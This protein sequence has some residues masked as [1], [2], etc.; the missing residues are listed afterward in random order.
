MSIIYI[1]LVILIA[2]NLFVQAIEPKHHQR[3]NF[4]HIRLDKNTTEQFAPNDNILIEC[5]ISRLS[6]GNHSLI[7]RVQHGNKRA[8]VI[9]SWFKDGIKLNQYDF[10]DYGRIRLFQRILKIKHLLPYDSGVYHCEIIS[11][12]GINVK[13]ETATININGQ[14]TE[15]NSELHTDSPV[16]LDNYVKGGKNY[17]TSSLIYQDY[18]INYWF[19]LIFRSSNVPQSCY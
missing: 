14:L 19:R 4:K 2:I 11:G 9:T 10:E 17:S 13:S 18:L 5:P 3:V 12:S 1:S 8:A 15:I 6:S 7:K 16:D